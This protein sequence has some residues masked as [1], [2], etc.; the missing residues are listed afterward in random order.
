MHCSSCGFENPAEAHDLLASVYAWFTE[1][2]DTVDLKD[3]KAL[4]EE[5]T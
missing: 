2:F 5:L 4:L 3:A 1:G